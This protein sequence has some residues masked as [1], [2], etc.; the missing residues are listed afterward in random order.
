MT[1]KITG[2]YN[3]LMSQAGG[4]KVN[5]GKVNFYGGNMTGGVIDYNMSGT[6]SAVYAG[7][8]NDQNCAQPEFRMS[9]NARIQNNINKYS[10]SSDEYYH[11]A[12]IAQSVVLCGRGILHEATANPQRQTIAGRQKANGLR[13]PRNNY[14]HRPGP[15]GAAT[16]C[17]RSSTFPA[18][19]RVSC[20]R[21]PFRPRIPAS[22]SSL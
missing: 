2:G 3:S 5:S 14:L 11:G 13:L 22:T 9:G 4:I 6:G 15:V 20:W 10:S 1:G 8:P 16:C 21:R 12:H 17:S 19:T 7:R 18:R